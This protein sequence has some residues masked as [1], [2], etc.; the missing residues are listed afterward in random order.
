MQRAFYYEGKSLSDPATYREVAIANYLDPVEVLA[1]FED[2][3][4]TKD[5]GNDDSRITQTEEN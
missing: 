4:S 5:I 1:R 2:V 3:A